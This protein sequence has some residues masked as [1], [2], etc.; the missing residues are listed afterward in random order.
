MT[1]SDIHTHVEVW[2]GYENFMER[3]PKSV[4]HVHVIIARNAWALWASN[5]RPD[6]MRRSKPTALPLTFDW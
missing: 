5:R 3:R 1:L 6:W 4:R 2:G